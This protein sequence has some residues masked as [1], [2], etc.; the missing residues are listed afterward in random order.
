MQQTKGDI[1][2]NTEEITNQT[3]FKID[4]AKADR[5]S[6]KAYLAGNGDGRVLWW[7][8]N[9]LAHQLVRSKASLEKIMFSF[10]SRHHAVTLLTL[11][12]RADVQEVAKIIQSKGVVAGI[13]RAVSLSGENT[14]V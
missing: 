5:R 2:M 6:V 10:H 11:K 9:C 14:L 12:C 13:R 3:I 4:W 1:P 8:I 7:N